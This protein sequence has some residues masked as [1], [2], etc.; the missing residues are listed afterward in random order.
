MKKYLLLT[1]P[2]YNFCY[3]VWGALQIFNQIWAAAGPEG[4]RR[5][6]LRNGQSP[7]EQLN[8]KLHIS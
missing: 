6:D 4:F 8:T 5:D 3:W 1:T 2:D 7:K